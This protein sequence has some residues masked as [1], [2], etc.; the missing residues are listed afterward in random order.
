[1]EDAYAHR[2]TNGP[3]APADWY[4][5]PEAPAGHLRYW[6]GS[7]WTEHRVAPPSTAHDQDVRGFASAVPKTNWIIRHK[8][9]ASLVALFLVV[10]SVEAVADSTDDQ[11]PTSASSPDAGDDTSEDDRDR[12]DDPTD[13]ADKTKPKIRT[14][15]VVHVVDGDTVNLGNGKTVRL[16]GIDAP[17]VGECGY[18]RARNTLEGLV[19]GQHVSLGKSDE[20]HDQYGRLLRYIDVGATDAGLR[21]IKDGLAI[22]R[23]DS[24]DGYG[25]HPREPKYIKAD[26][27]SPAYACAPKPVPLVA[28]PKQEKK[29]CAPG[30]SPCI[31]P[32]PPDLN[33]PDIGHPV[34]VT[35]SDPH[36]LDRDGDGVACEWS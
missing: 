12:E 32:Y 35:G 6:D 10:W 14:F 36:G 11:P 5:D 19:L 3:S 30:Y 29:N 9:L 34:Q 1:V 15:R 23:Y 31:R 25:F 7:A 4:P 27:A 21:L 2:V 33:C 24:R 20:D 13:G 22:A 16:A 8:V 28:Q 17:E 26:R 18:R